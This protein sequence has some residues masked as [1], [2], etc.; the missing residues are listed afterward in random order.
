[1]RS[2]AQVGLAVWLFLLEKG[3]A[4]LMLVERPGKPNMNCIGKQGNRK[5]LGA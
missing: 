1:M 3:I 4:A 5:N 2:G